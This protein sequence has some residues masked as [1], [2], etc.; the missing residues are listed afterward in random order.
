MGEARHF[1]GDRF[2]KLSADAM[3]SQ[4]DANGNDELSR[5]EWDKFWLDVKRYGYSDEVIAQEVD[6]MLS[7]QASLDAFRCG[8]SHLG[9]HTGMGQLARW[10]EPLAHEELPAMTEA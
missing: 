7:G 2:G 1:F 9:V 6:N 3:F 5:K 8:L 10:Q 4:I